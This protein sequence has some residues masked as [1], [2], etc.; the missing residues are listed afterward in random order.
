MLSSY[1]EEFLYKKWEYQDSIG[2]LTDRVPARADLI[3]KK[4]AFGKSWAEGWAEQFAIVAK[5]AKLEYYCADWNNLKNIIAPYLQEILL[6]EG[7][8]RNEIKELLKKAAEETYNTYPE[9]F[10]K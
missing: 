1:D 5:S 3:D 6:N 8:T 10:S 7:I 4:Y 9:S 2:G